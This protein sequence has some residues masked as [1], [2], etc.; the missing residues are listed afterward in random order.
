MSLLFQTTL[1]LAL[2]GSDGLFHKLNGL[3]HPFAVGA[4]Q[5]QILLDAIGGQTEPLGKFLA[6]FD[7]VSYT[8][9]TLPTSDLV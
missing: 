6:L 7:A 2:L 1:L 9:L 3:I 8:H 5:G 4:K